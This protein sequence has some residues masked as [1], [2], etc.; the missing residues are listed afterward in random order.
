[1]PHPSKASR[2]IVS[3]VRTGQTTS[4]GQVTSA[5]PGV[6]AQE[7]LGNSG[8]CGGA[9]VARMAH[10]AELLRAAGFCGVPTPANVPM[11]AMRA[12][13]RMSQAAE[14][15]LDTSAASGAIQRSSGAPLPDAIRARLETAFGHDFSHVRVHTDG[16]AAEASIDLNALAFTLGSHVFFGRGQFSPSSSD[17]LEL[18]AHE[19]MHVVQADEHRLPSSSGHG[20][21]VSSPQDAHEREA[22]EVGGK[23][24]G[25]LS[26]PELG[27][28]FAELGDGTEN[29]GMADIGGTADGGGGPAHRAPE[30]PEDACKH[31]TEPGPSV[32]KIVR[33]DPN[34]VTDWTT[35]NKANHDGVKVKGEGKLSMGVG[36]LLPIH[37][38]SAPLE[39]GGERLYLHGDLF[40]SAF[41]GIS[42]SFQAEAALRWR[43]TIGTAGRGKVPKLDAF[44]DWVRH[45]LDD[46]DMNHSPAK[47][48]KEDAKVLSDKSNVSDTI[49]KARGWSNKGVHGAGGSSGEQDT[50]TPEP[51]K[52]AQNSKALSSGRSVGGNV[53]TEVFAGVEVAAELKVAL[54]WDRKSTE[55]YDLDGAIRTL[56]DVVRILPGPVAMLISILDSANDKRL[57]GEAMKRVLGSTLEFG[58]QRVNLAEAQAKIA[59]RAGAGVGLDFRMGI[60]EGRFRWSLSAGATWGLGLSFKTDWG[61]DIPN[62][63]RFGLVLIDDPS[64][65]A[66][67]EAWSWQIVCEKTAQK[68]LQGWNQLKDWADSDKHDRERIQRGEHRVLPADARG[69]MLKN[70]IGAWLQRV[71]LDDE[72]AVVELLEF[73]RANGDVAEVLQ[74][75]GR[76][77][78]LWEIEQFFDANLRKRALAAAT[79]SAGLERGGRA[80][81]E[82]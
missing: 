27:M 59:A 1:M 14:E 4:T 79:G 3:R 45:A 36:G 51:V 15:G 57:I 64:L 39:V 38:G 73:S 40:L 11:N 49:K 13:M 53:K 25:Q 77:M 50:S 44:V 32:G 71:S 17:G 81:R 23:I 61:V 20:L 6:A 34:D 65:H 62:G 78:V 28:E 7:H 56:T 19:L 8:L 68:A 54:D 67:L 72:R 82:N 46:P 18:I 31:T 47:I 74:H 76:D 48:S 5:P 33:H 9:A 42:A 55:E 80:L 66:L 35:S 75:V 21:D 24:A 16:A 26:A 12:L 29:A 63:M 10:G 37:L 69:V 22:V 43:S 58:A 2:P 52:H 70:L 60:A 30:I 41:A